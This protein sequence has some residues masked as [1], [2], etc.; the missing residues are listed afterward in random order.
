M[1]ETFESVQSLIDDAARRLQGQRSISSFVVQAPRAESK[2][3][4]EPASETAGSVEDAKP[5]PAKRANM[6][7][8]LPK[9]EGKKKSQK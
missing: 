1:L 5:P 9:A 4:A 3:D 7:M 8:F 6:S 2:K